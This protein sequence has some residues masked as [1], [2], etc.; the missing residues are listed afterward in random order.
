MKNDLFNVETIEVKQKSE[1]KKA[2]Y[3]LKQGGMDI[4]TNTNL[5]DVGDTVYSYKIEQLY[6]KPKITILQHTITTI[7]FD[8]REGS[9]DFYYILDHDMDSGKLEEHLQPSID[10]IKGLAMLQILDA[11]K[12]A[13][14]VKG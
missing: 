8:K 12:N 2:E 3:T 5:Y 7:A 10:G 9:E 6:G 1:I 13:P 11:L 4:S 14:I